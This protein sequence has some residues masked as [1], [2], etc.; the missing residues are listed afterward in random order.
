MTVVAL[1]GGRTTPSDEIDHRVKF[2]RL[3]GLE[4]RIGQSDAHRLHSCP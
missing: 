2:D 3:E 1:G 4:T